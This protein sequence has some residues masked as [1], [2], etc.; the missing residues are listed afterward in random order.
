MQ[1][2]DRINIDIF[3][4]VTRAIAE[5][6]NLEI[7]TK[8]LAQL[9]VGALEIKGATIFA[10]NVETK[11]LEVSGQFRSQHSLHE[12]RPDSYQPQHPERREA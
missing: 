9:L 8:H 12:Q 7:M 4:V 3:K 5:S 11:E 6:N 2:E 1:T 10:T